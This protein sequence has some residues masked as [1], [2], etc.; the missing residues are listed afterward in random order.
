MFFHL[1]VSDPDVPSYSLSFLNIFAMIFS[2]AILSL[3]CHILLL[4]LEIIL[5]FS[6]CTSL[7]K[8]CMSRAKRCMV[9]ATRCSPLEISLRFWQDLLSAMVSFRRLISSRVSRRGVGVVEL[10]LRRAA[11]CTALRWLAVGVEVGCVV[12]GGE[13]G[14]DREGGRKSDV[15]FALGTLHS[16]V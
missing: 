8:A 5:T 15:R 2:A 3:F 6:I 11:M 12:V 10:V 13:R 1:L 9:S 14:G 4:L 7:V 16:C